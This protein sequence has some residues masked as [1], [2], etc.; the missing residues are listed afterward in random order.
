[1][2]VTE[3]FKECLHSQESTFFDLCVCVCV[4]VFAA[5]HR[6][7]YSVACLL[8]AQ[9]ARLDGTGSLNQSNAKSQNVP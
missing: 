1:M 4:L 2:M 7:V 3:Q 8:A 5:I 6:T 9:L